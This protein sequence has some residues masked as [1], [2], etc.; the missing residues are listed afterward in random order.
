ML[1]PG[2]EMT[3]QEEQNTLKACQQLE[4]LVSKKASAHE[5]SF[6]FRLLS[7]G[8]KTP[9]DMDHDFSALFYGMALESVS[10]VILQ[11]SIKRIARG[12]VDEIHTER[13]RACVI[14]QKVRIRPFGK[15]QDYSQSY[16]EYKQKRKCCFT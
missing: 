7:S 13:F 12:E 2:Y 4:E 11:E 3:M 5:I 15:S 1:K 16:H 6:A 10:S 8:M 9:K 14:L